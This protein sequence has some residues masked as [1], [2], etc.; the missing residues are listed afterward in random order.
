MSKI[1]ISD[2]CEVMEDFATQKM[3]GAPTVAGYP[4]LGGGFM[5]LC[6]EH[7]PAHAYITQPIEDIKAGVP[8]RWRLQQSFT[9]T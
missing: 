4:A 5:A 8:H 1:K 2:T 9:Q 7:A 3:C 6:A